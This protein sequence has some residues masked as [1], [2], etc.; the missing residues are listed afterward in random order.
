MVI[1]DAPPERP[2][3]HKL[4]YTL[5]GIAFAV[6]LALGCWYLL[7]FHT[8][9]NTVRRFLSTLVAGQI[10]NAYQLW[11][12]K[13]SY[14]LKDFQEDWGPNG[15]YGPVRSYKIEKADHPGG[16]S[17]VIVIV[18]LSPYTPFPSEDDILKQSKTKEARLWVE[19]SNQAL[20]FAP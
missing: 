16:G 5:T 9:V 14:S 8:E 12:P 13:P 7:R 18:E 15:Y 10:E 3:S 4:R 6:L 20:S 17:G 1:L 11:Q 19:F 2:H